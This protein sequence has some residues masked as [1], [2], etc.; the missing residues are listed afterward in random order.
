MSNKAFHIRVKVT[1][2]T[3]FFMKGVCVSDSKKKAI[4]YVE[5]E[6]QKWLSAS[7]KGDAN[8]RIEIVECK[9]L[10]TDF[11]MSTNEKNSN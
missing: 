10:R 3:T 7:T 8:R 4:N 11:L 2:H 5:I 6:V 1:S 9:E